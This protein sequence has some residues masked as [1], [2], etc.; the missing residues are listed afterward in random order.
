MKPA[1]LYLL[2]LSACELK[3]ARNFGVYELTWTCLSPEGCE[4]AEEVTLIDC[5][6][7]ANDGDWVRLWSTRDEAF[8][9][10][11]EMVPAD[12]LPAGCYGLHGFSFFG[13]ETESSRICRTSGRIELDLSIPNRD[14]ATHSQWWVEGREIDC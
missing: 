12:E 7:V 3:A 8:S 13:I 9:D 4:R 6:E 10:L 1:V 2:L 5:A 14:P 11:A